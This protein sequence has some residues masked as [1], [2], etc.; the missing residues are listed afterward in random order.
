MILKKIGCAAAAVAV[1]ATVF[2]LPASAA[3][4]KKLLTEPS[5]TVDEEG[6]I[7][8]IGDSLYATTYGGWID[9][10]Y[11]IT[12]KD[13]EA[14]QETG[15]FSYSKV[16]VDGDISTDGVLTTTGDSLA[17]VKDGAITQRYAYD[18]NGTDTLTVTYESENWFYVRDDGYM[19]EYS[20]NA[21]ELVITV[22]APDGGQNKAVLNTAVNPSDETASYW[23]NLNC[24]LDDYVCVILYVNKA[25]LSSSDIYYGDVYNMTLNLDLIG[26]DGSVKTAWTGTA[27]SIGLYGAVGDFVIFSETDNIVKGQTGH[28][29]NANTGKTSDFYGIDTTVRFTNSDGTTTD[30]DSMVY[31]LN[32]P[33]WFNGEDSKAVMEYV[34][35]IDG[36]TEYAY[37]LVDLSNNGEAVSG[38]YKGMSSTD[39]EL[40]LVQTADDKW[41]YINSDGE[42]LKA[43]DNAGYFA[44]KY[45]PVVKDGKAF[46]INKSMQRVSEKIDAE[47][48]STLDKGLY[49]VKI[50]G[51]QYFMTYTD[52]EDDSAAE[53]PDDDAAPA[54]TPDDADND[55][56]SVS[57]NTT[58]ADSKTDVQTDKTN[59][60]TGAE[61]IVVFAAI[62][63][64]SAGA[65][66]LSKKRGR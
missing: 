4:V 62:A 48:V 26:K 51:E 38:F 15:E 2:A 1:A 16:D 27:Q 31:Y 28:I 13:R 23:W 18:F 5:T 24:G 9:G 3:G 8:N 44:G 58:A 12:D 20:D 55:D 57:D 61:P 30:F 45:A 65:I 47:G 22:T 7:W 52:A 35:T 19:V 36:V 63:A 60:D 33:V 49:S 21:D 54:E 6:S 25:E 66:V 17:V 37:E 39:G 53:A 50:D 59:P 10:F 64:V 43:F 34:R 11:S 46:L 32:R 56:A 29:Y 42:L 40:Y 14:W 41:G